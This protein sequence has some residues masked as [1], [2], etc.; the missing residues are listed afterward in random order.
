MTI[1]ELPL[2]SII[3]DGV[4]TA[5]VAV[6]TATSVAAHVKVFANVMVQA[7][8]AARHHQHAQ[9]GEHEFLHVVWF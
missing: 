4:L 8:D 6:V 9:H 1:A 7:Q 5:R 3:R 2:F